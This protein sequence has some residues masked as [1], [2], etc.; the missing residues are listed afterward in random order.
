MAFDVDNRFFIKLAVWVAFLAIIIATLH[1]HYQLL[2]IPLKLAEGREAIKPKRISL[3]TF[4]VYWQG[5][6]WTKIALSTLLI[7][8]LGNLTFQA[9]F[10]STIGISIWTL[11]FGFCA[12]AL[13]ANVYFKLQAPR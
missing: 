5:R 2:N 7:G 12:L 10:K 3:D 11:Y 9:A 6:S 4:I 1:L 8:L 13:A